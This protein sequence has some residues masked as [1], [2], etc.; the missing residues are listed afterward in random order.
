MGSDVEGVVSGGGTV[1]I[2]ENVL[3]GHAIWRS[4][5]AAEGALD[6]LLETE[7]A[8]FDAVAF[9]RS[10]VAEIRQSASLPAWMFASR[11]GTPDDP[12]AD[13]ASALDNLTEVVR[14][15]GLAPAGDL[16][17]WMT[18][19]ISAPV[20]A[21]A[22]RLEAL[23]RRA[24]LPLPPPALEEVQRLWEAA[25]NA[26]AGIRAD[27]AA[28]N[29]ERQTAETGFTEKLD[30]AAKEL[31]AL[32][33]KIAQS[34]AAVAQQVQRLDKAI[35]DHVS[36]FGTKL[37]EW[38]AQVDDAV[39]A[40]TPR[41][42]GALSEIKRLAQEQRDE[43][44]EQANEQLGALREMEA[45][46][47]ALVQGTAQWT[48][49][50]QYGAYAQDEEKQA[51]KWAMGAVGLGC[52]GIAALFFGLLAAGQQ[53]SGEAFFKSSISLA[54]LTVAGFMAK[55]A[56]GHHHEARDAK[57]VQLDLDAL[58]PFVSNLGDDADALKLATAIR[59]F[60]RPAANLRGHQDEQSASLLAQA[61]KT[62]MN[63]LD[64]YADK[65]PKA[66]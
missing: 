5:E 35:T 24:S 2:D 45:Q 56:S 44:Q 19:S 51:A 14:Q 15:R 29:A 62:T 38:Q 16:D 3:Q 9:L 39:T 42:E 26:I 43:W 65:N 60:N 31:S 4:I 30:A 8:T 53:T 54:V 6:V 41:F 52:T 66:S 25:S 63:L 18:A 27:I 50:H 34:D 46:A 1:S 47:R 28:A 55:E 7:P 49:S 64:K 10:V 40:V 20:A 57:R 23:P 12:L 17:G 59:I 22:R 21:V 58:E 48:I 61:A 32:A 11:F 33:D 13:L 37:T 36:T